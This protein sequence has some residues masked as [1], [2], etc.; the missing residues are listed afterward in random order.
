M[1]RL[2]PITLFVAS[3]AAPAFAQNSHGSI[4]GQVTD[5]TGAVIPKANVTV[6]NTDTGYLA[7]VVTT[8]EGFYTAPELPP[9]PY[10]LAVEAKG[11]RTYVREGLDLQ[12]QQNATINVKLSV[13]ETT[14]TVEVSSATPLI[15]TADASTG[16]V[17]SAEEVQDL[18]SNGGSPLGFARI[19]YG[20][21]TKAKHD[22]AQAL[23]YNNSTVDD[24]SLGGGNSSSN[25]LLLNGVPNMQDG[26]RTAGF[27]PSLDA[28]TE[29]RVDVFGANAS[30][31]DTSGGTVNMTTKSGT[32]KPHGS[33]YWFYE[34]AGCSSLEGSAYISRTANNCSPLA[35]LPYSTKVGN[36]VPPATHNNHLGFTLGGPIFIPKIFDGRNK[37]FFF[38]AYDVS[39][40][41]VPPATTIGSVP[42]AAERSGDFSALLALGASY[43]LYNPFT[44][45]G[46]TTTNTRSPIPG[47]IFA[48]A[49]LTVSP[50]AQAYYKLVP[51]PNYVGAT[52]TADGENN[53]FTFTPTINN[54]RSHQGRIDYNLSSKN[55]MWGE[56]HR[57]RY[58]NTASNY[59]HNAL[60]GTA[61]DGILS[62]GLVED[63]QTFNPTTFLDVR[64]SV[65]RYDNSAYVSSTGISPSSV[66]FA[67]YLASNSTALA[68]PQITFSD[69]TNPLSYSNQPGSFE[70]FDTLQ[71]FATLTKIHNSHS[72][73]LG[74]DI[75][76]Y[77]GSY[78]SPGA[79]NGTFS[80][81]RGAGSPV[82]SGSAASATA[83]TFGSSF[84]LFDLAIPTGGSYSVVPP[85]QYD[86]YLFG[87]FL[88]DNWKVKPNITVT[89]GLRF[90]HETPVVE[91]NNRMVNGFNPSAVNEAT[92]AANTAYAAAPSSLL[93]A[94]S[95]SATG[96]AT[97]ATSSN[98]SPYSVAPIYVSPRVGLA[99]APSIFKGK[100]VVRLG[101]GVYTNPFGDYNQ[102]QTYGYSGTTTYVPTN[103][104][105]LTFGNLADPFPVASNPIQLPT[106]SALGVNQNLGSKMVYYSPVIKVPY[107]ERTSLDIQYQFGKSMFIDIGYV[108]NHQVHLSYS[109]AVD[110]IPLLPYLS[111]SP[112][113]N[114]AATDLLTGTTVLGGKTTN[115]ANP[116]L[117][118][119]GI[120]GA[121]ATN[122][123]LSPTTYLMTNSEYTSVTEQLIPG[124][125]S[126][127]NALNARVFKRMG[128]GLTFNGVF[129][130]SRLLGAFNQLNAGDALN[131]GETTSDYPYHVAAYGT[132]Q[133]P[134]G[135]GRSFFNKSRILDPVIGGWQVTAIYQFLSGMPISWGNAIYAGNGSWKDFNNVQHSAGNRLGHATFNTAAFDTRVVANS[136]LPAQNNPAA[137]NY[138]PNIQPNA[139]NY[140]TFP[141]YLLRQDYTSN[142]DSNV[143]KNTV[144]GEG[145]TMQLRLDIFNMLNRPQYNTPNVTP[146]S[147][148]FGTTTGVYSGTL[149][150]TTQLGIHFVF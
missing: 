24:F 88:Q 9:G 6:T 94:A 53:Y 97:F 10:K 26:G 52:T 91:S 98:R 73:Q 122:K 27:S 15:D 44:S 30:Y 147:S 28:V 102:G 61:S 83:V 110:S 12:T 117:G 48:N 134:F 47:N 29:I 145:V 144:L 58:L 62:G 40:G 25:E 57:S 51:L 128:H 32:N 67:G 22:L 76:A 109:N 84:A 150:R 50:I 21:V 77:K 81:A 65:T 54:Y 133:L 108:N 126:N 16:Q 39:V 124:S 70:N 106:G 129:E 89:L 140:R 114:Q 103:N 69:L 125:G 34:A 95:F 31:G 7:K 87:Y 118:L 43:Q 8:K 132:Y 116:Y 138:N 123:T 79:A 33:A 86:S 23:P 141:A 148:L 49:G 142:W 45:V 85:F 119:P 2:V 96:G 130:W 104:N 60:T 66:G 135:R 111:R 19:E 41:Q 131:Y 63:V 146:T 46:T 105:G 71:L 99:W 107:S 115:I 112:Y 37:L 38:Y 78:L 14:E 72:F 35:A 68:L 11:F 4:T 127:Y 113:Y 42:T 5:P 17:L 136:A 74:A 1:N 80:F 13:G 59:F 64:G 90:E 93:P 100:G 101:Y 3:L 20:V 18:P 75:R 56:A 36:A 82:A 139:E 55:K 137:A 143:Q 120:T 92:V 149:A 121:L